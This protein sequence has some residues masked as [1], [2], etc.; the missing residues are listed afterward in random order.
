MSLKTSSASHKLILWSKSQPFRH[1]CKSGFFEYPPDSK[2]INTSMQTQ[3][4]CF[5]TPVSPYLSAS[6]WTRQPL[7]SSS[8]QVFHLSLLNAG[9]SKI[10]RMFWKSE[11]SSLQ[12]GRWRI[13]GRNWSWQSS[14]SWSLIGC[15]WFHRRFWFFGPRIG[16]IRDTGYRWI[17]TLW[18]SGI[19]W[20]TLR[21]VLKTS[22]SCFSVH[23]SFK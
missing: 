21:K 13:E 8:A 7:F 12:L 20:V 10:A 6:L 2:I 17:S 1:P 18:I 4:H 5:W 14:W 9:N 23:H 19:N 15:L 22:V 16:S 11:R 3:L